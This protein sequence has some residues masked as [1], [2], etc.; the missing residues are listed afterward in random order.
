MREFILNLDRPRRLKFG[1]KAIRLI[2]EK[3]GD[4]DIS[5][6]LNLKVDEMPTV[7]WAGL[8]HEEEG[9]TVERV[10]DLIDEQIPDRYTVMGIV[11]III[12]A[13][14]EQ[15]GTEKKTMTQTSDEQDVRPSESGSLPPNLKT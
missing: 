9:L 7:A 8:V 4:R 13:I 15:V 5:D 11:E 6:L 10:S 2:R 1:F 12:E 14:S 3:F